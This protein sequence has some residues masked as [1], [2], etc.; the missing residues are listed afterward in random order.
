VTLLIGFIIG[1]VLGLTGA[2]GSLLAVPL[3]IVLLH[4]PPAQASG[5]ALGAVAA[6]AALGA[7]AH[8]RQRQVLWI[9]ALLFGASG[10]LLAPAGRWLAAFADP[11][12]LKLAFALLS[13]AIAG[14]ML[15]QS[16]R[17]PE[18]AALVRA[19]LTTAAA[20]EAPSALPCRFSETQR[21][22]WRP[23]CIAGLVAGGVLTGLL[24][25][26]FGVGGGF[27]IIPFLRQ[28]NGTSMRQAVATSLLIVAAISTSGF[29]LDLLTGA[30]NTQLLPSLA[31]GS[32]GGM[33]IGTLLAQRVAGSVLE[34]IFAMA[35][36]AMAV[37]SLITG[38]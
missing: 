33:I 15:W 2:G 8:I 3:L 10:M 24:S 20:P 34:R 29:A 25:G 19:N 30:L 5:L 6:S 37:L 35:I 9:P 14:R 4:L 18:L 38:G 28:L 12:S 13:L 21:F 22:E 32:I 7:V 11:F 26:L 23:R 27:L 16:W 36:V 31:A 1:L 17:Q